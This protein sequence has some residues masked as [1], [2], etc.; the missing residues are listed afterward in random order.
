VLGTAIG[1]RSAYAKVPSRYVARSVRYLT[2]AD[3]ASN[4][5]LFMTNGALSNSRWSLKGTEDLGGRRR[6][7]RP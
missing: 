7:A 6:T 3:S 1:Y 5:K 2:N 4:N